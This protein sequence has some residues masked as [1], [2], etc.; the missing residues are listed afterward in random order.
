MGPPA[1]T[2]RVFLIGFMGA[3]KTSVGRILASRLRWSFRDLDDIIEQNQGKPVARIFA[4]S[5]EAAFRAAESLALRRTLLEEAAGFPAGLVLAL[6]GGAFAQP[7]NREV[8]HLSGGLVVLLHAPLDE[9]RTRCA[10]EPGKRPL[11]GDPAKFEELYAARRR[12]YEL[13]PFR[14]ETMNKA[15]DEVAAEIESLIDRLEVQQ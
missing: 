7:E 3:G 4:E 12:F 13:A 2:R 1:P 11:A 14:V 9:L 10:R 8:L 5:G 6:G 15:V